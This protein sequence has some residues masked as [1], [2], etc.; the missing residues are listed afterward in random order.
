MSHEI[1][2]GIPD[3]PFD[4]STEQN[5]GEIERAR[6]LMT[7]KNNLEEA[8]KIYNR[9]AEEASNKEVQSAYELKADSI[10]NQMKE[11]TER[12]TRKDKKSTDNPFEEN[13]GLRSEWC[14]SPDRPCGKGGIDEACKN[15]SQ[16]RTGNETDIDK[17]YT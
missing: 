7:Y 15:C 13:Y 14:N 10:L 2:D 17:K 1:P 8:W 5:K 12:R 16:Y 11:E 9:L 4:I 6:D 3:N